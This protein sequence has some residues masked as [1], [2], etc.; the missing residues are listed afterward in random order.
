MSKQVAILMGGWSDERE[1]S[2]DSGANCAGALERAGYS[3]TTIDVRRDLA[4]L[5]AALDPA[6]DVVFNAL[7]GRFGEDGCIQGLLD[8]LNI[9][10]THSGLL[11]SALA[12]DKVMAKRLFETVGIRCADGVLATREEVLAG[13]VMARPYVV[14]PVN[15]GS[16]VGVRIVQPGDEEFPFA[17]RPWPYGDEVLVERYVPGRELTVGVIGERAL[18]VTEVQPQQGFYDYDAKYDEEK[19]AVHVV[20][21]P[22]PQDIY[23]EAMRLAVLAHQTLGCRGCSRADFRYD[24]AEGGPGA[25]TILEI[26]TQPGMTAMSLVPEQAAHIGMPIEELVTWMV[27]QAECDA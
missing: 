27:E 15:E 22:V 3:V 1:V 14:K 16:S 12:M 18:A 26:N 20:P 11:A 23:D 4:A 5:M 7:H 9:P 6:P 17:G 13:D 8:I 10:Y 19:A 21:A 24:E 25:I 2:L